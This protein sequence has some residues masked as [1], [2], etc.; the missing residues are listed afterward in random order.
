MSQLNIDFLIKNFLKITTAVLIIISFV[1]LLSPF[2][3]PM[4]LGGILAMAFSPSVDYFLKKGLSRKISV[5]GISLGI[6]ILG[7]I[8]VATVLLKGTKIVTHFLSKQSLSEALHML[9]DKIYT[10]IDHF[11][12]LNS[13][14]KA[15]AHLQFDNLINSIGVSALKFFTNFFGQIPNFAMLSFIT[16]LA[17]YFFL[18]DEILIRRWY[19]KFFNFKSDNGDRFINLLKSSCREVFFSNFLTGLIQATIIGVGAF[20]C[21]GGDVFVIFF[22]AFFLSF[23]PVIGA[24][25]VAIFVAILIFIEG[26]I[27]AGIGMSIVA[28]IAG[29]S[30]NLVR[31]YLNSLGEVKVPIFI[32]FLSIIGGVLLLG[33]PGLFLGPLLSSL[34]Y[35]ALPIILDEYF[36]K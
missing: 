19:D 10:I 21:N 14:D 4:I 6:F 34:V 18:L 16:V 7:L 32:S 29:I 24:A 28:M 33:L 9:Q 3:I 31:P 36:Q 8:P 15:D 5:I 12:E 22:C 13:I 20:F 27:G 17:F 1:I 23:I 2:F 25:P 35:G 30:D 11:A 26:R